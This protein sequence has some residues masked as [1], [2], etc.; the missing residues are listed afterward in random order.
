VN[1]YEEGETFT[2]YAYLDRY[3]RDMPVGTII[4]VRRVE[5]LAPGRVLTQT[6]R[7]EKLNKG[8]FSLE[9][10]Q[11]MFIAPDG[12][13]MGEGGGE[14]LYPDEMIQD[15]RFHELEVKIIKLGVR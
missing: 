10:G 13:P 7:Y 5:E 6:G 9:Y 15:P 12:T 2:S 3:F 1:T 14:V 4:S 8:Y 11:P